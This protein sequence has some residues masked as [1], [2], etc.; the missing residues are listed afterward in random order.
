M[1]KGFSLIEDIKKVPFVTFFLLSESVLT[2]V[3]ADITPVPYPNCSD[4]PT[5]AEMVDNTSHAVSFP[6][7]IK[8]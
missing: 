6:S 4:P 7:W 8:E 5:V 2:E 1:F 3:G